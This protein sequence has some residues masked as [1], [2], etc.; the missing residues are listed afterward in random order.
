MRP[1]ANRQERVISFAVSNL[2]AVLSTTVNDVASSTI[3]AGWF[4]GCVYES[5]MLKLIMVFGHRQRN[6][7][8]RFSDSS[9][10]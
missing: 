5:G 10:C 2:S 4:I 9:R 3:S 1:G 7:K 8:A 6:I